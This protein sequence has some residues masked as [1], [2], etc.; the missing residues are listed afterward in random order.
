MTDHTTPAP[1]T[2]RPDRPPDGLLLIGNSWTR[3][4]V[5]QHL[6]IPLEAV[7]AHPHL[8]RLTGPLCYDAAFPCLQFDDEGVRLDVAVVAM[9]ARRRVPD[10]VVCDWL[11]RSNPALGGAAP[12]TWLDVIGSVQPV[13]E[14]LPDPT[15]P[16][17]GRMP[18]DEAGHHVAG[19]VRR[20]EEAEGRR[21]VAWDEIRERGAGA[22]AHPH[23]RALIESLRRGRHARETAGPEE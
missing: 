12:L 19:W 9:L 2:G 17:P 23:V 7:A 22:D 6:A 4:E 3:S 1:P 11:V 13:L 14:A 18:D 10:D 21:P 5:A 8:I 16:L 15:G 20:Q